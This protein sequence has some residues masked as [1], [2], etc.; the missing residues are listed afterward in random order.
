MRGSGAVGRAARLLALATAVLVAGC[1]TAVNGSPATAGSATVAPPAIVSSGASPPAPTSNSPTVGSSSAAPAS[2]SAGGA[3]A[4]GSAGGAPSSGSAGGASSS[5][6]DTGSFPTSPLQ[7]PATA[8]NPGSANLLEARRIGGFLPVPTF[9]FP[10]YSDVAGISTLPL[11][12]ADALNVLFPDPTPAVAKRAGLIT[13]FAASRND[14]K[15]NHGVLLAAFEFPTAAAAKAAQAPIA[16]S[17]IDKGDKPSVKIP[18]FAGATGRYYLSDSTPTMSYFLAQGPML[19]Y[20]WAE[21]G[22]EAALLEVMAKMFTATTVSMAPFTPTPAPQIAA[23]PMDQDGMLAH[24]LPEKSTDRTVYA[25]R[26]SPTAVIHYFSEPAEFRSDMLAAQVDL[27]TLGFGQ[28]YR[29]TNGSAA[30]T[31]RDTLV[32]QNAKEDTGQQPYTLPGSFPQV[33]C[34]QKALSSQYDCVGA[35]GRYVWE[36]TGKSETEIRQAATAQESMLAGF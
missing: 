6:A 1:S 12:N 29:T 34:L 35:H 36:I 31:L 21:A 30:N 5:A 33:K 28:L 10:A 27:V 23:L 19:L 26:Y 20:V 3:P 15:T 16:A 17:D 4:S 13:G 14:P 24:T 22:S 18:G 8:S 9:V 25:G 11:R 32:E 7:L 2:G